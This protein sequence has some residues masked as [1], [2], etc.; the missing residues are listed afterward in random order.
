VNQIHGDGRIGCRIGAARGLEMTTALFQHIHEQFL[1]AI[2]FARFR[3]KRAHNAD[4][5]LRDGDLIQ[6]TLSQRVANSHALLCSSA[7][8]L[9]RADQRRRWREW[10]GRRWRGCQRW[11]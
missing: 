9:G 5:T 4:E 1:D 11:G 3:L 7:G 10:R 2:P 8:F 6:A